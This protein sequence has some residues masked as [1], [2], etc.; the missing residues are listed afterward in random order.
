MWKNPPWVLP[1]ISV[2]KIG[3][4]LLN[5]QYIVLFIQLQTLIFSNASYF[6]F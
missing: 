4:V 1:R 3:V 6:G 5:I 2:P